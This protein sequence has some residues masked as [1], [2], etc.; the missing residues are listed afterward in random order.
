MDRP[1]T[2]S[3]PHLR[4]LTSSFAESTKTY[5]QWARSSLRHVLLHSQSYTNNC[6]TI[7][8]TERKNRNEIVNKGCRLGGVVAPAVAATPPGLSRSR[9]DALYWV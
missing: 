2:E 3:V 8:D 7:M 4:E 9:P 6:R 1:F 5:N